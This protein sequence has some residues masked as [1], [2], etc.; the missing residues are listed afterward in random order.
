MHCFYPNLFYSQKKFGYDNIYHSQTLLKGF[1]NMNFIYVALGGAILIG[2]VVGL[3]SSKKNISP[4]AILF[5]K[6]TVLLNMH[7]F[8]FQKMGSTTLNIQHGLDGF[9]YPYNNRICPLLNLP[10]ADHSTYR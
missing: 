1:Q 7:Q 2:F 4:N 3:A 9:R 6:T 10:L 8:P 5:L